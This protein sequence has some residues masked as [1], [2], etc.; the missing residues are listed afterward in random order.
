MRVS[1]CCSSGVIFNT[2]V[3]T[4][5]FD[6]GW[7]EPADPSN[8]GRRRLKAANAPQTG[9]MSAATSLSPLEC[10]ESMLANHFDELKL[11]Q[12][13]ENDRMVETIVTSVCHDNE[14]KDTSQRQRSE[15]RMESLG[16]HEDGLRE[17]REEIS[18]MRA[19]LL[20]LTQAQIASGTRPGSGQ[21]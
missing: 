3:Q 9:F 13:E 10:D 17:L 12:V 19:M 16:Q 18:Q 20:Q 1:Y 7:R 8:G 11:M 4:C 14:A 15:V 5:I 6:Q 2:T 21:K